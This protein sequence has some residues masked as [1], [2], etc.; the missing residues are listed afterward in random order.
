M[1]S[2]HERFFSK[3]KITLPYPSLLAERGAERS[4]AGRVKNMKWPVHILFA[5]ELRKNQTAEEAKIWALVRNRKLNGFK[6][7]RQHPIVVCEISGKKGFYIADF[8][9]AEKKLVIEIDGCIHNFQIEYDKARDTL[10]NEMGFKVIRINNKDVN[11][12]INSV[13]NLIKTSL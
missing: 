12:N 1:C 4:E 10:M 6:F 7:L 8:Y 3:E 2:T 11:E 9:C 13:I 5:R